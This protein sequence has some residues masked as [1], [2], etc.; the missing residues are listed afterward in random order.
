MNGEVRGK[1]FVIEGIDGSGKSTQMKLLEEKL[2]SKGVHIHMTFEPT[3]NSI[4]KIV[5]SVINK[6][7]E[8]SSKTLAALFLADRIDHIESKVHGMLEMVS[9][10]ITVISDRYY[11][12]SFAYHSLDDPMEWVVQL[13]DICRKLL[14]PDFTFF[15][16]IPIET[17]LSRIEANRSQKDL[18][19]KK[20]VLTE[21]R[22]NYLKAFREYGDPEEYKIIDANR[23]SNQIFEEIW[24]ILAK[25][26]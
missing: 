20:E 24:E 23:S 10:G 2:E 9:N 22:E 1:F 4:G 25:Y 8:V 5:R 21:V 14:K 13:N 12:S 26:L 17:S 15:L 11:W 16:D 19:E 3:D 18:F 6:Q 7:V